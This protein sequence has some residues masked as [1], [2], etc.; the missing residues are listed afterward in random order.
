MI[1][2]TKDLNLIFQKK[3]TEYSATELQEIVEIISDTFHKS[4][5]REERKMLR[6]KY[7]KLAEYYNNK[8]SKVYNQ[9][10]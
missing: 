7:E 9:T 5:D 3:L 2:E 10:L 1:L 4:K 6:K 8:F